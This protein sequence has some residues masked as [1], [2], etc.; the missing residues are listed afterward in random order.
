MNVI[1]LL[2]FVIG[3]TSCFSINAQIIQTKKIKS[4]SQSLELGVTISEIKK[5]VNGKIKISSNSAKMDV[6]KP[7]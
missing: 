7:D 3:I 4:S 2:F 5:D 1:K 6:A